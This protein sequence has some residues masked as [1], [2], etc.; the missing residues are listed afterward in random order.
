MRSANFSTVPA[1][2]WLHGCAVRQW[3]SF[4]GFRKPSRKQGDAWTVS[5][6]SLDPQPENGVKLRS[7]TFFHQHSLYLPHPHWW[8]TSGEKRLSFVTA[9]MRKFTGFLHDKYL[10]HTKTFRSQVKTVASDQDTECFCFSGQESREVTQKMFRIGVQKY[11]F[12]LGCADWGF[13]RPNPTKHC[14]WTIQQ[15]ADLRV[16]SMTVLFE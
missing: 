1:C 2:Q 11:T 9:G 7:L 3:A 16:N 15:F 12:L 6:L 5:L 14:S 4:T 13:P 10:M 8:R